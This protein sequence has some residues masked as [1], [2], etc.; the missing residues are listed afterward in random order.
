[1][2]VRGLTSYVN[3]IETL[4]TQTKLENTKLII[5]GSGLCNNLYRD[6]FDC[7]HG[8][9]YKQCYEAV[10]LFF[11][12]LKSNGVESFVVLNGAQHASGKKLETHKKRA[13]QS[14][15]SG[16]RKRRGL[17]T[18]A[19]V[20]ACVSAGAEGSHEGSRCKIRGLRQARRNVKVVNVSIIVTC[21][22]SWLGDLAH[23][24]KQW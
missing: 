19:F 20:E 6:L 2:G 11:N 7:W 3:S 22:N 16:T 24:G 14:P 13:N 4:W 21:M 23:F 10:L 17:P 8:G 5:D 1:M 9:Q 12:T 15:E 18:S